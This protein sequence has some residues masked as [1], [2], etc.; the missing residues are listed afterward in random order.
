MVTQATFLYH[1]A[2]T[3]YWAYHEPIKPVIIMIHGFRGTHHGLQRIVEELPKYHIV[4]PDLPG[5]GV[6]EPLSSH[7]LES[8]VSWLY[9]FIKHLKLAQPPILLGHSFGSIITAHFAAKYPSDIA[10]LILVNPIGAPALRGPRGVMTRL[11]ILYYWLGRALPAKASHAWLSNKMIV[12]IMSVTMAK[13][14]DK[15]MLRYIH[16]QHLQHFSTFAN[17][18]VVAEAFTTSVSHDVCEI[19]AQLTVPTLLIAGEKDDITSLDKQKELHAALPGSKLI[20]IPQVGH[21]IHY[22][23]AREAA[24]AIKNF[25]AQ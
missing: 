1:R 20:V 23:T 19:A 21:L 6:S 17:P 8:Y 5:F 12:K 7:D 24:Q 13:S 2:I 9:D 4:V 3:A 10:K 18:T 16:D 15:A 22:E 11:A 14:K 25:I